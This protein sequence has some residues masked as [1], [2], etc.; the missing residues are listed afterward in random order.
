MQDPILTSA[1]I[2]TIL[3]ADDI[4]KL[5]NLR[6]IPQSINAVDISCAKIGNKIHID[7]CAILPI[8]STLKKIHNRINLPPRYNKIKLVEDFKYLGVTINKDGNQ[9]KHI[10]NRV[11]K[12]RTAWKKLKKS[13]FVNLK[14]DIKQK[15]NIWKSL[16]R[17]VLCYG[18]KDE[19][20]TA[21]AKKLEELQIKQIKTIIGFEIVDPNCNNIN[22]N[23][24]LIAV[25]L[26][27]AIN[28]LA[29]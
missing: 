11:G 29:A 3:Y 2:S 19:L 7:K 1:N 13:I 25:S 8:T 18:I 4:A 17:S 15:I 28:Y 14:I 5:A 20:T 22:I 24:W 26:I 6:D 9:S 27:C 21:Q 23:V 16:V 12:F 10:R